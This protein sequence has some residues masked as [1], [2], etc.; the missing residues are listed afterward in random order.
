MARNGP[1]VII[2]D[3]V[4]DEDI[5]K[6]VLQ[7]LKVEN[8]VI[9]FED[10]PEAWNYLKTTTDKPLI[11]F[12]DLNLPKQTGLD[13]KKQIDADQHL[14]KKSIPFIFYSTAGSQE[15]V[16]EAYTK[17]TVQG[18]F[19]KGNKYDEIKKL[20]RIILDYWLIC[21]HPNE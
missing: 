10:S 6:E 18:F 2:E 8:K 1:V 12:C 13:F 20:V 5:L 21:R 16:D 4:D 3:D 17:M 15:T 9:C 7:E 14:R 19:I 11:I